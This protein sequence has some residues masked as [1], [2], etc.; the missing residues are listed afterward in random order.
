MEATS[1]RFKSTR[2]STDQPQKPRIFHV[3]QVVESSTGKQWS[4]FLSQFNFKIIFRPGKS[5]EKPDSLTRRSGDLPMEGDERL[6]ANQQAVLKPWNLL[7]VTTSSNS[8][9]GLLQIL[10]DNIVKNP[11]RQAW[12][13]L[14]RRPHTGHPVAVPHLYRRCGC[15]THLGASS[16]SLRPHSSSNVPQNPDLVAGRPGSVSFLSVSALRTVTP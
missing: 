2:S 11:V 4:E 3:H 8:A 12:R 10:A 6:V 15:P 9:N 7:S 5:G 16:R 14:G 13:H 1:E